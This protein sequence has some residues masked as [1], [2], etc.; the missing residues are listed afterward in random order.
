ME[1]DPLKI[2]EAIN[3]VI[4][5]SAVE[6]GGTAII[7]PRTHP[8]S[9]D[10]I[11]IFINGKVVVSIYLPEPDDKEIEVLVPKVAFLNHSGQGPVPFQYIFYPGDTGNPIPSISINYEIH[12]A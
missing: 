10:E 6:N 12:L 9:N 2:K 4:T 11:E 7:P 1:L 3:G 8:H 5:M